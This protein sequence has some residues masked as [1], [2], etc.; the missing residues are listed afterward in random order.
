V[1]G[2]VLRLVFLLAVCLS[3]CVVV[4]RPS[5]FWGSD[6]M[7]MMQQQQQLLAGVLGGVTAR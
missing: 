3:A 7:M 5:P 1:F 2:V 4:V 6:G